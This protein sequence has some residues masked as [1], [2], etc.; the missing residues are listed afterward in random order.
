MWPVIPHRITLRVCHDLDWRVTLSCSRCRHS[1]MIWPGKTPEKFQAVSLEKLFRE[2]AFKC[3]KKRYG[4]DGTPASSLTV[5][6]MNVGK[7]QTVAE[8]SRE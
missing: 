5:D 8:W 3:R 6:A 4:C 1:T 2:G 7:S